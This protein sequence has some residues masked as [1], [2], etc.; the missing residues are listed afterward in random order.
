[1]VGRVQ[2]LLSFMRPLPW[3]LFLALLCKSAFSEEEHERL[4]YQWTTAA[5]KQE[6]LLQM[7][8]ILM[9]IAVFCVLRIIWMFVSRKRV[10]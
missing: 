7:R 6:I 2:R 1:V 8:L 9:G 5:Y 4:T 10:I 3:A